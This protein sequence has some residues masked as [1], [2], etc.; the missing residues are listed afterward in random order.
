MIQINPIKQNKCKQIA[1]VL[2]LPM[3]LHKQ[4]DFSIDAKDLSNSTDTAQ[5]AD[6]DSVRRAAH[7]LLSGK[8]S[9][10]DA[11]VASLS[12]LFTLLPPNND[13]FHHP[14]L[15]LARWL[16]LLNPNDRVRGTL[17]SEVYVRPFLQAQEKRKH[18]TDDLGSRDKEKY[19]KLFVTIC[20]TTKIVLDDGHD[21][22]L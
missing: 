19:D 16:S 3:P 14:A 21:L 10:G 2:Q 17:R 9:V 12:R 1:P 4:N 5:A 8:S 22:K 11:T 15:G 18:F 13:F 20:D 6:I 7:R